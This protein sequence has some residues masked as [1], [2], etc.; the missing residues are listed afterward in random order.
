MTDTDFKNDFSTI[1]LNTRRNK[2]LIRYILF[3]LE[4]HISNNSYDFEEN[5]AT[6]EHILPE[7]PSEEWETYFSKNVLEN[8][9]FRI[10]NYTL[11][12]AGKNREIGNKIYSEKITIFETSGF[13]MTKKIN[14]PEWN[15][16]NLDKRQSDLAKIATSIWRIN[17]F[18]R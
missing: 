1:S 4:N 5:N 10:G 18:D 17:T 14:F 13:E 7:N 9:V 16:N 15:A 12:E 8:Y 11:L 2:K 3:E 6:I